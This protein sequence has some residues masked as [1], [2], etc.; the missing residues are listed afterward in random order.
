MP[1]GGAGGRRERCSRVGGRRP[2]TPHLCGQGLCMWLSDVCFLG[3]QGAPP[4][5]PS[6]H[7]GPS[8][9]PQPV[10]P[11]RAPAVS[12]PEPR[13]P[14]QHHP[15]AG[16]SRGGLGSPGQAGA[17]QRLQR[18]LVFGSQERHPAARAEARLC[19]GSPWLCLR[20]SAGGA[21]GAA[22]ADGG[23]RVRWVG[24]ERS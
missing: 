21:G 16:E 23:E 1:S 11:P 9:E 2:P 8:E 22:A 18:L 13:L 20:I 24:A 3:F 5:A 17:L 6:P 10:P 7:P 19:R 12:E 15:E 14:P 4:E